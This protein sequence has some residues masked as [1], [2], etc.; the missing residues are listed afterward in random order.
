MKFATVVSDIGAPWILNVVFF[1]VLGVGLDAPYSGLALAAL[2]GVIPQ[3]IIALMLRRGQVSHHHVT[4]REQR[5]PVFAAIL[6]CLA[7]AVALLVAIPTPRAIRIALGA[8]VGFIVVYAFVTLTLRVKISVHVGLWVTV[9]AYLAVV[10]SPWWA[11]GLLGAPAVAWSRT[12][13]GHH[14]PREIAGGVVAGLIV[15]GFALGV[16]SAG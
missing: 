14:T 7:V 3:L 10:L 16:L 2:T 13:L 9:W 5:G 8:A 1:L 4:Q 11:I 12:K 15:L 6:I